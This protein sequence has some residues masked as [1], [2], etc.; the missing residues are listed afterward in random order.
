[1]PAPDPA[2]ATSI[3]NYIQDYVAYYHGTFPAPGGGGGGDDVIQSYTTATLPAPST[4]G[5][6]AYVTDG[7][8]GLYIDT[9]SGWEL[10][11]PTDF[12][13]GSIFFAGTNGAVAQNNAKLFWNNTL[14]LFQTQS[15]SAF[16][17]V[18]ITG[19]LASDNVKRGTGSPE[20]VVSGN[21]GDVFQRTDGGADTTLYV[22]ESGVGTNTGWIAY[23][24]PGGGTGGFTQGSVPFADVSGNLIEDNANLF[25]DDI[26]NALG[27]GTITPA[28]ALDVNRATQ[29]AYIRVGTSAID[30]IAG[31]RIQNDA[32]EY[33][34]QAIGTDN[35][36]LIIRDQTATADRITMD[37]SGR[38]GIGTSPSELFEVFGTGAVVKITDTSLNS[39]PRVRIQNDARY[40]DVIV[41][42]YEADGFVIRDG[43]GTFDAIVVKPGG[44]TELR[45]VGPH[46]I[47]GNTTGW[48]G[49]YI[50]G[51]FASDGSSDQ[52]S[53]TR[54]DQ[55][56]TGAA[57]DTNA[58]WGSE[59]TSNITT[60][61]NTD[62]IAD[63]AQAIFFEPNITLGAGDTITNAST[64]KIA[65]APTEATNNYALWVD[66]GVT[67]IDGAVGIGV[68]SSS[69]NGKVEIQAGNNTLTSSNLQVRTDNAFAVDVGGKLG[70]GGV[71]NASGASALF[72]AIGGLKSNAFDGDTSG[73]L[74]FGTRSGG[75]VTERMRLNEVGRLSIGDMTGTTKALLHIRKADSGIGPGGDY[76]DVFIEGDTD[77]TG[78]TLMSGPTATAGISF[79][80]TANADLYRFEIDNSAT[81]LHIFKVSSGAA[82]G[83][84]ID[85]NSRIGF[86]TDTPIGKVNISSADS[87][88]AP[89]ASMDELFIEGT[90]AT[91]ITI[92]SGSASSARIAYGDELSS[93]VFRLE[94]DNQANKSYIYHTG[95]GTS[96]GIAIT[97]SGLVGI[98]TDTPAGGSRLHVET[99][100]AILRVESTNTDANAYLNLVPDGTGNSIIQRSGI[101]QFFIDSSN[102]F[103][104]GAAPSAGYNFDIRRQS[105]RLKQTALD[106]QVFLDLANDAQ[107]WR[108]QVTGTD[109]DKFAIKDVNAAADRIQISTGG[110]VEILTP[111][112]G[113]ALI[114]NMID[115]L[116][117]SFLVRQ[118]GNNYI[119]VDTVNGSEVV[120]LGNTNTDPKII[121]DTPSGLGINRNPTEILDILRS[122]AGLDTRIRVLNLDNTDPASNAGIHIGSGGPSGGDAFISWEV[123]GGLTWVM[124]VDNSDADKLRISESA[125]IGT[126]DRLTLDSAG[127]FANGTIRGSNVQRGAGDPEGAVTGVVGDIYQRTDGGANTTL[128]VKESGAGTNTGWVAYGPAGGG[129][130]GFTE[131]SVPFANSAGDL[132]EDNNNLFFN[133]STNQLAVGTNTGLFGKLTVFNTTACFLD[134]K[135]STQTCR[136]GVSTPIG[137]LLKSVTNGGDVYLE[138]N[139]NS[140]GL[141]Q[142]ILDPDVDSGNGQLHSPSVSAKF[143][144]LE[145]DNEIRLV[146]GM[147]APATVSGVAQIYVDA[148][149]GDLKVKFGNGFVAVLAA[150]S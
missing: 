44:G 127:L 61:G 88:I 139:N 46:A 128:Y 132:I 23:G 120:R 16:G 4:P 100:L 2:L 122:T 36:K 149:D 98:G 131:G 42:N 28:Q 147:T 63:I 10:I 50:R 32:R 37:S 111:T 85:S 143:T 67:R 57:L 106:S 3:L 47:G 109:S 45:G 121:L 99:G 58:L 146:D 150:D 74:A 90:S 76:D 129:G 80:S 86:G 6:L 7:M 138:A 64:L 62:T 25:Y 41:A 77:A 95:L 53:G 20:G 97:S 117:L 75:F 101:D 133:D 43:T 134:V 22:K 8:P 103:G 82:S 89:N 126:N 115:N 102:N 94:Y 107:T 27:I 72:A 24:A 15:I 52:A 84:V 79:G 9:G 104:F 81:K 83:I 137:A 119:G 142:V 71:Y 31:L 21:V 13:P 12:T 65:N 70:L 148:A 92:V 34:I 59:F 66:S 17:N 125:T 118:G 110:E 96:G 114:V 124:G 87:G 51:N 33:V 73:Y 29:D 145:S 130:G 19:T 35:D 123:A 30:G 60:Q 18:N 140:G 55:N 5:L 56:I 105:I 108:F 1:M 113:S 112:S 26:G 11:G 68:T 144:F 39:A 14:E 54:F 48:A 38:V 135:D 93:D 91:G 40:W 136:I 69:I 49:L 78:M 141:K 116:A